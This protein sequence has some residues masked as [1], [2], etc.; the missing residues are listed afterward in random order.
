MLNVAGARPG[1]R[2]ITGGGEGYSQHSGV[3]IVYDG[4]EVADKRIARVLWNDSRHRRDAAF[5]FGVRDREGMRA[6]DGLKLSM[7]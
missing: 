3:V 6:G 1:C 2:C 7:V 5:G 4:S